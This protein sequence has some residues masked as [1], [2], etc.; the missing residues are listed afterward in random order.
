MTKMIYANRNFSIVA[1]RAI[2]LSRNPLAHLIEFPYHSNVGLA[3]Q[4]C[5]HQLSH[6]HQLD[7][8]VLGECRIMSDVSISLVRRAISEANFCTVF[9]LLEDQE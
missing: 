2:G 3:A 4:D 1:V 5:R 6:T 7:G 9:I 8:I